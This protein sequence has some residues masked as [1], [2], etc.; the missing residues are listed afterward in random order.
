[1]NRLASIVASLVLIPFGIFLTVG[2]IVLTLARPQ[3]RRR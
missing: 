2:G 1:M 3:D